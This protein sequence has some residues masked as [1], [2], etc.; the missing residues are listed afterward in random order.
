MSDLYCTF[1]SGGEH[2]KYVKYYSLLRHV[3]TVVT[4]E[5]CWQILPSKSTGNVCRS[6]D[7]KCP[8]VRFS[9]L[10]RKSSACCDMYS[11]ISLHADAQCVNRVYTQYL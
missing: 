8:T 7:L 3:Q 1:K 4:I 5:K 10:Y 9:N 11:Q 2:L 6:L